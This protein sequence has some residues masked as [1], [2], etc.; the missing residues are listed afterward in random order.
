MELDE[1]LTALVMRSG[2]RLLAVAYQLTH[3][4]ADAQDVVQ[5]AILRVYSSI[6]RRGLAPDD[7]YPYLRRAVVNEYLRGRR[8]RSSSEVITDRV[9]DNPG[10]PDDDRLLDRIAV[11]AAL[12]TLPER[13]RVV[14][15]LRHYEQLTDREIAGVLGCREP[16]VRS[17]ARRGLIALRGRQ[18][19]SQPLKEDRT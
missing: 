15:V 5:E 11:W 3:D 10:V 19:E 13:Q 16:T 18:A 2:D 1:A 14:L 17:L 8:R 9:P 6:R 7:L 4:R 12:A